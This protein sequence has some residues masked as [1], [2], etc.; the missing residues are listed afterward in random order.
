MA[1][2]A[3]S[4]VAERRAAVRYLSQATDW[5]AEVEVSEKEERWSAVVRDVSATGMGLVVDRLC[6]PGTFLE[7]ELEGT[8]RVPIPPLTMK[9][10]HC[11]KSGAKSYFLGCLL[12]RE[13]SPEEV[14][15]L[16]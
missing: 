13:L 4:G 10:V 5:T 8:T 1:T 14:A 16:V 15:A 9:V 11:R 12:E 6:E 2:P 3:K 7:V